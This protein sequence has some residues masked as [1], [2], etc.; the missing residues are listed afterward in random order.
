VDS[1]FGLFGIIMCRKLGV[2]IPSE[3]RAAV[4]IDQSENEDSDAFSE[5]EDIL[6]SQGNLNPHYNPKFLAY[7]MKYIF[8]FAC[9]LD[10]SLIYKVN[11]SI[12]Q[13]TNTCSESWN[14]VIL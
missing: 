7:L 6:M 5:T 9:M 1:P 4:Q 14:S 11:G 13:D 3:L 12:K 8:P 2:S 10:H